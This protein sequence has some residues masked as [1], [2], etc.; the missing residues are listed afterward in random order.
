MN[1]KKEENKDLYEAIESEIVALPAWSAHECALLYLCDLCDKLVKAMKE[2]G[3]S[4]SELEK[5]RK[6]AEKA[7]EKNR[8]EMPWNAYMVFDD[9]F[10][11]TFEKAS[12]AFGRK[13]GI[14]EKD[15][16]TADYGNGDTSFDDDDLAF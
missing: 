5:A 13:I 14:I 1:Q 6:E 10:F 7:Y 15:D 12:E 8:E 4:V 9:A 2:I 3:L 16:K 11:A